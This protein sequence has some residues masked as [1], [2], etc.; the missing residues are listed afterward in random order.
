MKD[1]TYE[2]IEKLYIEMQEGFRKVNSDIARLEHDH[3]EKL[4][5]LFDFQVAQEETNKKVLSSLDSL[6]TRLGNV[7]GRLGNVERIVSSH[8]K[9]LDEHSAKLDKLDREVSKHTV[10]LQRIEDKLETHDIQIH[11]LDKTKANIK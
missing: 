11:V 3:G 9:K 8:S 7:E 4:D 5:A 10:Q 6:D 1:K 2:L